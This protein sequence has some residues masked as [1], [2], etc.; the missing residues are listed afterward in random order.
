MRGF[1][2][3]GIFPS[4]LYFGLFCLLTWPLIAHFSTHYFT[5]QGDGLQNIWNLWWVRKSVTELHTH[6]WHTTWLHYPHGSTLIGQTLNPFNGFAAIPLQRFLTLTEAH[7]IIVVS[8]FVLGGVTMFWLCRYVTGSYWASLAGG[9]LF[10]FSSYH[11]AHAEGHMQLISLEWLPLFVLFWLRLFDGRRAADAIGAAIALGLVI[12]CDYYYFFVCVLTAILLAAWRAGHQRYPWR[13]LTETMRRPLLTFLAAATLFAAPLAIGLVVS[14]ARD[15][16]ALGGHPPDQ[17]SLD[18]FGWLIPGGH[19]R[20]HPLTRGFW[21]DLPGTIHESSVHLGVGFCALALFGY[22]VRL[23]RC[24]KRVKP[25]G[26]PR[27]TLG[28]VPDR[29]FWLLLGVIFLVVALGPALQIWG[30]P[31]SRSILPYAWMERLIPMVKLGGV[32]VRYIIVTLLAASILAS[33]GL[34]RLSLGGRRGRIAA[35]ALFLLAVVETAPR[36]M[37]LTRLPE[38][39]WVAALKALPDREPVLDLLSDVTH[40]LYWQVLYD[41]PQAFGYISRTPRSVKRLNSP[42]LWMVQRGEARKIFPA[43]R[44]RY[45]ILSASAAL[46]AP[47]PEPAVIYRDREAAVYDL[48]VLSRL[49]GEDLRPWDRR[50]L[51]PATPGETAALQMI[52]R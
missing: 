42:L 44:I 40:G 8:T 34:A 18:L 47:N 5:D 14:S 28:R 4:L 51:V 3:L 46:D 20:F 9:Y 52:P 30:E 19:W 31:V 39:G 23:P 24:R 12:L 38:P 32:P 49:P 36:P 16:F 43:T 22:E 50:S 17:F 1:W 48:A 41:R 35:A 21:F 11:F 27:E 29:G 13:W 37:P 33:A 10:T 7:N 45:L 26:D 2:R 6:P 25:E 15:P